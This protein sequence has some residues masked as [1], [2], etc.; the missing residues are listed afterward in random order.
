MIGIEFGKNLRVF[1]KI[2][3][4]GKG[5]IFIGNNLIFTSGDDLNPLS[6]NIRGMLFTATH[7]EIHIG[8]NVGISS[9]CL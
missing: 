3:V 2:H 4:R 8:D 6:R 7:G 5:E 1:N 9:A